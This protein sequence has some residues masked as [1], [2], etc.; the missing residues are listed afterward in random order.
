MD[1]ETKLETSSTNSIDLN[2]NLNLAAQIQ[3]LQQNQLLEQN[4]VWPNQELQMMILPNSSTISNNDFV[5]DAQNVNQQNLNL[6]QLIETN[7]TQRN[8]SNLHIANLDQ[9]ILNS[10]EIKVIDSSLL[11]QIFNLQQNSNSSNAVTN[12]ASNSLS[13]AT[14]A[15]T[16]KPRS[17]TRPPKKPLTPYMIFSKQVSL[18]YFKF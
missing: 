9:N 12:Q 18:F 7:L 8:D 2:Q 15:L 10:N 1:K 13:T 11:Q 5:S 6:L 4:V 14:T 16:Q 17:Y 3:L